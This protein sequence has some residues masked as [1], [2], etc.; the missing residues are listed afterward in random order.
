MCPPGVSQLSGTSPTILPMVSGCV[1]GGGKLLFL[2]LL[3]QGWLSFSLWAHPHVLL[4]HS[5]KCIL[6]RVLPSPPQ[7]A[8]VQLLT[9]PCF[10]FPFPPCCLP[11][12]PCSAYPPL[13]PRDLHLHPQDFLALDIFLP[14]ALMWLPGLRLSSPVMPG[15]IP[16]MLMAI[17]ATRTNLPHCHVSWQLQKVPCQ[18]ASLISPSGLPT[19]TTPW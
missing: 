9:H 15:H 11:Y 8:K 5:R 2:L 16:I 4:G 3:P 1:K 13:P 10:H 18:L 17:T 6:Y 19:D 14:S 12:S 7:K